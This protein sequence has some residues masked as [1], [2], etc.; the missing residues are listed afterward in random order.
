MS[1]EMRGESRE[2]VVRVAGAALVQ[3]MQCRRTGRVN[4]MDIHWHLSKVGRG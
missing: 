3:T 4:L 1:I 2:G